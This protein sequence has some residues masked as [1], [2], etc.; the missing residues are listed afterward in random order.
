M[1]VRTLFG[2][3]RPWLE[4]PGYPRRGRACDTGELKKKRPEA[5]ASTKM[6]MAQLFPLWKDV[7]TEYQESGL[8]EAAPSNCR[9][10]RPSP[11][12]SPVT[13]QV[14][15][16]RGAGR[17]V[18]GTNMMHRSGTRPGKLVAVSRRRRLVRTGD[19]TLG[20][21]GEAA[22][23]RGRRWPTDVGR[24]SLGCVVSNVRRSL[25]T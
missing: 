5:C 20:S 4:M 22:S 9:G 24:V 21:W 14:K 11:A 1:T 23:R 15:A 13:Q 12:Q 18:T 16:S 7:E 2:G 19:G 25:V 8:L 6:P 3:A 17:S 10:M